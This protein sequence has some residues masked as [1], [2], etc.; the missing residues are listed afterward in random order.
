M[1]NGLHSKSIVINDLML[2]FSYN[3]VYN[4]RYVAH[5][6]LH[7][8]WKNMLLF[9]LGTSNNKRYGRE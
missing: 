1:V 9:P 6:K 5:K 7:K 4:L 2:L 3:T 8:V